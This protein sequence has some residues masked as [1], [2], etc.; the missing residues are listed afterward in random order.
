M[1]PAYLVWIP[2]LDGGD[3]IQEIDDEAEPHYEEI[4]PIYRPRIESRNKVD[5]ASQ[6]DEDD[7]ADAPNLPPLN[8]LMKPTSILPENKNQK[9]SEISKILAASTLCDDSGPL[10]GNDSSRRSS[11][12]GC[13]SSG[14]GGGSGVK[15][16]KSYC[17]DLIQMQEFPS[18]NCS[19]PLQMTKNRNNKLSASPA[20][21]HQPTRRK[22]VRS[23]D[24]KE[25]TV[26][27]ALS[28]D[29]LTNT[30]SYYELDDIQFADDEE[31]IT[32]VAGGGGSGGVKRN[33]NKKEMPLRHRHQHDDSNGQQ[34]YNNQVKL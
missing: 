3:I 18:T 11:S 25:T 6:S 8:Q 2:P 14:G 13:S 27:K 29:N 24:E 33:D 28:N 16:Q 21:V 20:R 5:V 19:Y 34:S 12:S 15:I 23:S 17:S 26:V 30:D 10:N 9:N 7:E 31:E 32:F 22:A 1:D 4:L